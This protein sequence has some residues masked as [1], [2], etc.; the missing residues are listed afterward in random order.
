[1]FASTRMQAPSLIMQALL[2]PTYVLFEPCLAFRRA[3]RVV[4]PSRACAM[5]LAG[6]YLRHN[7]HDSKYIHTEERTPNQER[8]VGERRWI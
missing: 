5:G 2:L 3:R 7:S 1:M 4:A 8:G 6:D